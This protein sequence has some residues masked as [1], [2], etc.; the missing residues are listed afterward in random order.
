MRSTPE[1]FRTTRLKLSRL[2]TDEAASRVESSAAAGILYCHDRLREMDVLDDRY[3]GMTERALVGLKRL[4]YRGGLAASCRGT[5]C[6]D[7]NYYRSRP[8]GY[9]SHTHLLA[10][11][12]RRVSPA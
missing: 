7:I 11:L 6:G 2:V 3:E 8:Q 10:A 5:A 9:Q 12:A 1:Y 4:Y